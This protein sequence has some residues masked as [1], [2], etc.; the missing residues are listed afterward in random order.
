M[1][2]EPAAS[3]GEAVAVVTNHKLFPESGV[4]EKNEIPSNNIGLA[5]KLRRQKR[6][7]V[8][9]LFLFFLLRLFVFFCVAGKTKKARRRIIELLMKVFLSVEVLKVDE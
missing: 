7:V 9:G 5:H 6:N 2:P 8:K 3:Q 1:Q 4:R